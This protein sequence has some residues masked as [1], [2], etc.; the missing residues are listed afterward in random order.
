MK[1]AIEAMPTDRPLP[2]EEFANRKLIRP[3]LNRNDGAGHN[4]AAPAPERRERA[5]RPPA[6]GG[7]PSNSGGAGGRKVTPPETT[8]AENFYYQKQMQGKTP[9]VTVLRDGEEVHGVIEWYDKNCLK[10]NRTSEPNVV[11]YKPAIKYMY[12]EAEGK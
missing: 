7:A 6:G 11:I 5:P 9:M 12:K 4:H 10:V 3:S 2:Q 1:D 8:N